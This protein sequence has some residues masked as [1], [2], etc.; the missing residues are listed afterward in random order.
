M[1]QDD[2]RTRQLA[3][4]EREI[5]DAIFSH[6]NRASAEEIRE[7]LRNPPSGSTVR[8]MLTR[9]E[10][11]GVLRHTTDGL[12][13]IYSARI[14]PVSAKKSALQQYLRTHFGGSLVQMVT[15]L[16]RQESWTPEELEA[17]RAEVEQAQ[18]ERRRP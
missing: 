18:K 3:R 6:G 17:L 15:A 4:R 13:Y 16:V 14:S 1:G 9:L 5:V 2:R 11:K 8:V 12:R 10:K 7:R